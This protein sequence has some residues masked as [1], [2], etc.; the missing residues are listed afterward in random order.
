MSF[1]RDIAEKVGA[2]EGYTV[3]N[4]NGEH[5]YVEGIERVLSL[6]DSEVSLLAFG[7][8]IAVSGV[9][10]TVEELTGGAI[11]IGG[12]IESETVR[13]AEK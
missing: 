4:F 5:V 8:E 11:I 2:A 1:I 9:G 6:T 12:R 10:L 7:R 3:I 13:K